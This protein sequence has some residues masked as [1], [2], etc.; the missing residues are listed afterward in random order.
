MA[1]AAGVMTLAVMSRAS[2]GHTGRQLTASIATQGIYASIV[3]AAVARICAVMDPAH[4]VTLLH[5]AAFA[6]A[7]AFL[8]FAIGYGP[9]L[10]GWRRPP[11]QAPA[12]REVFQIRHLS[13]GLTA[14]EIH[15][16]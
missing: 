10:F 13:A 8:G 7:A 6:W 3:V 4:S 1:G 5:V 16:E 12:A 2:L 14:K 9:A 15:L 11:A